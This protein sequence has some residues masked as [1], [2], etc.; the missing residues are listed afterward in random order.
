MT[1]HIRTLT[2]AP[3]TLD[4]NAR[5]V[6]A[7]VSTGADVQRGSITERLDLSGA[8]LSRFVGAPVLDAH[9]SSSTRDQ[10]GVIEAAEIRPEGIWVRMKFRSND[11]AQA[12]LAD[13]A[14]GTLRGLSIGY[15]VAEWKETRDGNRRIRIAAKWTPIEASVVPVPADPG[16]HFRHGDNR[17]NPEEQTAERPADETARTTRAEANAAI[18]SIA[19]AAGLSRAWADAQ[20]DAEATPDTARTA[21]FEAMRQ[22]STETRT[23]S[24]RA[25]ITFDHSDPSLATQRAGE[26]LYARM[27]PGHQLSEAARPFAGMTML[28]L[29]RDSLRRAGISTTGM[30]A[31]TV[32]KRAGVGYHTTSD[33]PAILGDAVGR[34][35]RRSYA[36]APAPI[37]QLARQTTAKDFRPRASIALTNGPD[38]LKVN[39]GGEYQYGTFGTGAEAYAVETFGRIFAITRQALINDDIGAFRDIPARLG[40]AARA[41][42]AAQ[43]VKVIENNPKLSDGKAVFHADHGNLG[44]DGA[45]S[46]TTLALSRLAMR[47]Q[48]GIGGEVID[49]APKF[50]L[51]P[52]ELETVAEQVLADIAATTTAEANPFTG[53]TLIVEPRLTSQTRWYLVADPALSDGLEYA[54]LE[55]AAGPQIDTRTGFEI[56]GVEV[57]VRLDFGAGWIDHRAWQRVG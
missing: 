20:I 46:M 40:A 45:P 56:D 52:P 4:R 19:E 32:F 13:I 22:R 27:H 7:I 53:L 39:E 26:A 21:A 10:L 14:E 16:A 55:G 38:L 28:D 35:L 51:V 12:V 30:A 48:K 50:L 6:E 47:R 3:S 42:E 8:D 5:T 54:Y 11:A 44:A 33:F 24:Q 43:L 57:K 17:M 37:K 18:R 29:A 36:T 9:R 41:F 49:I 34:E 23:R 25:E 15:Q 1:I 2:P 31:E